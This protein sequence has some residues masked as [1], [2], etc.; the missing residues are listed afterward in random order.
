VAAPGPTELSAT[1]ARDPAVQTAPPSQ[2]DRDLEALRWYESLH[3]F[4]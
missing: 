4:G 2:H 3:W 1:E